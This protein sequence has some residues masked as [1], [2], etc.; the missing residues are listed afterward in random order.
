M[1]LNQLY[2]ALTFD[3]LNCSFITSCTTI[4]L[5]SIASPISLTVLQ[6]DPCSCYLLF[7][8]GWQPAAPLYSS[9]ILLPVTKTLVPLKYLEHVC[10]DLFKVKSTVT[11]H[12]LLSAAKSWLW[13]FSRWWKMALLFLLSLKALQY[14]SLHFLYLGIHRTAEQYLIRINIFYQYLATPWKPLS[15]Q[16]PRLLNNCVSWFFMA[17]A[18]TKAHVDT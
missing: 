7:S 15:V 16:Q 4:C 6:Q 5:S 1:A 8:Y 14:T 12:F 9:Y 10:T 17:V 11:G 18:K 2:L 13:K 3:K